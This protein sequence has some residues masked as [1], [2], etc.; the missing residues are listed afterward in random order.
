M[1]QTEHRQSEPRQT[2]TSALLS[3]PPLPLLA[4]P[5]PLLAPRGEDRGMWGASPK[6]HHIRR[7]SHRLARSSAGNPANEM[8]LV[9]IERDLS[10]ADLKAMCRRIGVELRTL[11]SD[12]LREEI[13]DR[14]AEVLQQL[15]QQLRQLDQKDRK[16][17][18]R[19]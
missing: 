15:D 10:P 4:P 7:T 8:A 3:D 19:S 11:H 12:A 17:T 6:H 16:S 14:I 9:G 18:Y 13:P 1:P 5:L 2:V